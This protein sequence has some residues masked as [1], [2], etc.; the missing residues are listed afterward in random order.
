MT[1]NIISVGLLSFAH[2]HAYSYASALRQREDVKLAGFWDDDADRARS[3][4]AQ[5]GL[6]QFDSL[7]E[8]LA[9]DIDAVIICSENAKHAELTLAAAAAKKH[10][11]CEKPLGISVDEMERMIAACAVN[12]VQLMTA[13]PCRY[14]PAVIEAKKS[15]ERGDIGEI[16]AVKGTN[17]GSMPGGWFVVPSASGGGAVLDHTVHVMDLMNWFVQSDIVDVYAE[18]ATLFHPELEVEDAGMVHVR[19]ESGVVASLDPSWSR[20]RSFPTWGDVTM[21]IIGTQGVISIDAF[22]QKSDLYS[23]K[24]TKAQWMYWGDDMDAGLVDGFIHAIKQGTEVPITGE[25]GLKSARVALAALESSRLEAPV[26]L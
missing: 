19:F 21:E 10:V 20:S 9:S 23:D 13:F 22:A 3:V 14:I 6:T 25:D 24:E 18:A 8:L 1:T 2:G 16:V 17:R 12:G 15:I 4:A 7:Q 5:L 11:M 26:K